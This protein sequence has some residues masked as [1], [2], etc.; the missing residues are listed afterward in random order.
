MTII[1]DLGGAPA[2]EH[3]AQVGQTPDFATLNALEVEVYRAAL[4]ARHGP[5]PAG[6]RFHRI[7]NSHDFGR[8]HTLGIIVDA[9]GNPAVTAYF[10]AIEEGLG[11]WIEAGFAPPVTYRGSIGYAARTD[12]A[13]IVVG[14]LATTRPDYHGHFPIASSAQ[15]HA[16]LRAGYPTEAAIYDERRCGVTSEPGAPVDPRFR[17]SGDIPLSG[18]ELAQAVC[19]AAIAAVA[20]HL[21]AISAATVTINYDG[22]GDEGQINQVSAEAADGT[23]VALPEIACERFRTG[24]DGRVSV[25]VTSLE[26]ALEEIGCE[27]LAAYQAGWENGD[28]AFGTV[29]IDVA[30]RKATLD[31]NAY[32]TSS[33]QFVHAL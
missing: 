2:N 23:P 19:Q 13:E 26:A 18:V 16:N 32:V 11:S 6:C 22:G 10:E 33:E 4:I 3:C 20:P 15:L 5:P 29:T 28:G 27:A 17:D 12:L 1:V 8:Y 25:D 7:D 14:A 30:A 9:F 21:E 24:Y 31:H